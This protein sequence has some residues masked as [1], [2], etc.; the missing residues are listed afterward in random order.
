MRDEMR[1][2]KDRIEQEI[3]EESKNQRADRLIK[4]LKEQKDVVGDKFEEK[5]S[6]DPKRF[7]NL[8]LMLE[9]FDTA[10]GNLTETQQS[11]SFAGV[12]P[13]HV[14]R[15]IRLAYP[16]SIRGDV[17]DE[18]V[19][20]RDNDTIYYYS[21]VYGST[22]RDG[23]QGDVTHEKS[24]HRYA[25][26]IEVEE[27][28][29]SVATTNYTGTL[30]VVPIRPFKFTVL[31]DGV[32]SANDDGAGNVSG[33]ISDEL[34]YTAGI[35]ITGT[36]D[37]TTGDYD[38]TF[39]AAPTGA[40]FDIEYLYD[41]EVAANY[42]QQGSVEFTLTEKVF[43]ADIHSL[44]AS[45]SVKS[46]ILMK[47][48]MKIDINESLTL[49]IAQELTKSLDFRALSLGYRTSKGNPVTNFNADW[50]TGGSDS[51]EAHA[52]SVYNAI[53]RAGNGIYKELQRGKV[54]VIYG[55]PDAVAYL[56]YHRKW[57]EADSME[58]IGGHLAGYINKIP[59][60]QVPI[61]IVP[62]DELVCVFN[63]V[64]YKDPAI[65][66][67]ILVPIASSTMLLNYADLYSEKA[68][69]TM[70]QTKVMQSKYLRRLKLLNL[71]QA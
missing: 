19:M 32:P 60:Y 59:V 49:N 66:S 35:T 42:P 48:S 70:E 38:I 26:T 52:Q 67:G 50:K 63:N 47:T 40:K 18:W 15:I 1:E 53:R 20:E 55:G 56:A 51:Q 27:I 69:Y 11:S 24:T 33:A 7:R 41:E 16:N 12:L 30:S 43:K 31:I 36:I 34:G 62:N 8:A 23:V 37:Y 45:W 64:A 10:F 68:V 58:Q 3:L 46:D 57:E 44:K 17:F 71:P 13:K 21:P 4:K 6:K 54:N 2:E 9:N 22:K 28:A 5:A 25:S 29:A 65:S 14:K 39:S 61:E